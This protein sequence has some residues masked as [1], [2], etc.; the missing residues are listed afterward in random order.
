M[1][2]T[3]ITGIAVGMA[4]SASIVMFKDDLGVL[5]I[6]SLLGVLVLGSFVAY[7]QM[8]ENNE[9]RIRAAFRYRG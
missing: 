1:R 5:L 6:G 9:S 4:L 2:E 8:D 3:F 7:G